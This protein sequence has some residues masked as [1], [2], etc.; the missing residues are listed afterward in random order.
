MARNHSTT[1][2]LRGTDI[3]VFHP[4][5]R[6]RV[7]ILLLEIRRGSSGLNQ[8]LYVEGIC[9]R[10]DTYVYLSLSQV[11]CELLNTELNGAAS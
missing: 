10:C 7:L 3:E 2:N 5:C 11:S 1:T 8:Y 4:V 9:P 6:S